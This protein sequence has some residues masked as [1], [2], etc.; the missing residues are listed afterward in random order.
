M[1]VNV[2]GG[3]S[4]KSFPKP[5]FS[6]AWGRAAFMPK[7]VSAIIHGA[8]SLPANPDPDVILAAT[9][10]HM[11]RLPLTEIETVRRLLESRPENIR[12][13]AEA[14]VAY[15]VDGKEPLSPEWKKRLTWSKIVSEWENL[16]Q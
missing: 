9:V 7:P 4:R 2:T 8:M 15:C 16:Q 10:S 11:R 13:I 5:R 1:K 12:Q 3:C 14:A 6:F